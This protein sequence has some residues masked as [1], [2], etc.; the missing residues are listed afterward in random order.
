MSNIHIK[1]NAL[2]VLHVLCV[3]KCLRRRANDNL[4]WIKNNSM[5]FCL[6]LCQNIADCHVFAVC[7]QFIW[8]NFLFRFYK[9][10]ALIKY[11]LCGMDLINQSLHFAI[12]VE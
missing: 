9:F 8:L 11:N 7:L 4:Q 2:H 12:L 1:S 5:R 6:R 3:D 10:K